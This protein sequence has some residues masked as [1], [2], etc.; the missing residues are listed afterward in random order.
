VCARLD[1]I[2]ED[3]RELVGGLRAMRNPMTCAACGLLDEGAR[4]WTMR[5]DV[6]GELV[7]FCP[8]CDRE[9]FGNG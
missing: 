2:L 3:M 6:D 7:A 5:L 1:E 9:E 4:G 8:D